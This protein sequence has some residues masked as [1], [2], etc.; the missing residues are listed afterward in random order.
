[1]PDKAVVHLFVN[2]AHTKFGGNMKNKTN[3][4]VNCNVCDCQYNEKGCKCNKQVIDVSMGDGKDMPNG[5]Q[6][7]FCKSFKERGQ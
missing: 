6:K 5:V 2:I 3:C 7:H 4:G 1:M